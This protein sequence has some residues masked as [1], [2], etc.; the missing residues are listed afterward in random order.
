M[1]IFLNNYR[2]CHLVNNKTKKNLFFKEMNIFYINLG[3][4][5][6]C[7]VKGPLFSSFNIFL[8]WFDYELYTKFTRLPTPQK[9]A[10][11]HD[12][13]HQVE[14]GQVSSGY[15]RLLNWS[16]YDQYP[17]VVLGQVRSGYVKLPNW[18]KH[19]Q[20]PQVVFG[21][22]RSGQVELPNCRSHAGLNLTNPLRSD[23]VKIG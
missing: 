21:L 10:T 22:V 17:Q 8:K 18:S 2:F 3:P 1:N 11:S 20:F 4:L 19:N 15:V 23:L 13:S 16:Q 5:Y 12:Q 6:D 7:F 9:P 14:I